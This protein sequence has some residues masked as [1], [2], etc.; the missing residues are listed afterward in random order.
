MSAYLKLECSAAFPALA[1]SYSGGGDDAIGYFVC[2]KEGTARGE[3]VRRQS[4]GYVI[5]DE[6]ED[7]EGERRRGYPQELSSPADVP[8]SWQ[9]WQPWY[10]Q[11]P[12]RAEAPT[13][14]WLLCGYL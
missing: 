12:Y 14:N 2:A 9:S 5:E 6:V 4:V 8:P 1:A 3:N 11:L 7:E 10:S 13:I